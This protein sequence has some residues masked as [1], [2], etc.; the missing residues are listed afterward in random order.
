VR[1]GCLMDLMTE[2]K[3]AVRKDLLWKAKLS[4]NDDGDV[5]GFGEGTI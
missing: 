4:Q 3:M 1:V 2:L 5:V